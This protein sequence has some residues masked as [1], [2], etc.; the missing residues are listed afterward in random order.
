MK[1]VLKLLL[2]AA[3]FTVSATAQ[4]GLVASHAPSKSV[5]SAASTAADL[6]KVVV[7]RVNGV[8]ISQRDLQEQ[9]QRLF[10]YYSM[11]GGN[12]PEKYQSEIHDRALQQLVDDELMYEAAKQQGMTVSAATMASVLKQ[13]RSRFPTSAAYGEYAKAQYGSVQDFERRIRRAVLIAKYQDRE[14]ADKA[15]FSDAKLREIYS[16]HKEAFVR[17]ESVWLQTISVSV[18]NNPSPEQIKMA[19]KRIAEVLP[20]AKAAK[21]HDEFGLLAEKYS[22]D[23]YRVMLGDHKWVHL[24]G[25]PE[26]LAKAAAAMKPGSVSDVIKTPDSL[27]ILRVNEKKAQKQMEFAEIAPSLRKQLEDSARKDRWTKLRDQLR[28]KAKVEV[29]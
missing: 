26:P 25:L 12:V 5:A 2:L 10:P 17:P 11:H 24:V 1:T 16:Q 13:A 19:E 8:S 21:N 15:K 23:D 27:V 7:A 4:T 20:K 18:P 22:E 6:Q 29:L 28:K 9:M 3:A 14:I